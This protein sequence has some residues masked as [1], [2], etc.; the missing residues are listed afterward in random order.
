MTVNGFPAGV[1]RNTFTAS[2]FVAPDTTNLTAAATSTS[3][4]TATHA[5]SVAVFAA[6]PSPTAL[7]VL[8]TSGAAPLTVS[9]SMISDV[10]LGQVTLDANG[11]GIMDF[12]GSQ[13]IQEPF[14][15]GQPGTYVATA[16]ATDAQGNQ[17]AAN[18][19]IQVLDPAQL[20]GILQARWLALKDALRVGDIP[21]AL[22]H[23]VSRARSRYEE[24]FQIIS[25]QLSSIDQILTPV[26]LVRIGNNEAIYK[27]SRTDD[28]IPMSFEVR[29]AMD[30]DGLWRLAS[31]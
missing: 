12:S 30:V 28:G 3:G 6:T 5:I 9:F 17:V 18:A 25:A 24:G 21:S 22:S 7:H 29:F 23:I 31:F 20:D 1:Q 10:Q 11:D 14:I 27:S 19:V 16:N 26:S 8:P 4:D 13:L 15:F 2:I